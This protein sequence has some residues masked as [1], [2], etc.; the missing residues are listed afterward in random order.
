MQTLKATNCSADTLLLTE[1]EATS[2]EGKVFSCTCGGGDDLWT[3]A[4]CTLQPDTWI[5]FAVTGRGTE[6]DRALL[7][8]R[9]DHFVASWLSMDC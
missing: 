3:D 9:G 2:V 5:H 1:E 7:S 6:E 8:V 4:L